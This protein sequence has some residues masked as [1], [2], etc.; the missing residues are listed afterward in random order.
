MGMAPSHNFIC[1][2]A[3]DKTNGNVQY[4][5]VEIHGKDSVVVKASRKPGPGDSIGYSS[6]IYS[7]SSKTERMELTVGKSSARNATYK[8]T[9]KVS[10]LDGKNDETVNV[11]LSRV[12]N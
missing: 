1:L 9:Y 3:A 4:Y 2:F 10:D 8:G 7:G 6:L 12:K 5:L 11:S